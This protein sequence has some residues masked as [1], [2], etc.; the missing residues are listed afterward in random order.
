M[1]FLLDFDWSSLSSCGGVQF[2]VL[3]IIDFSELNFHR[4]SNHV[5]V[6]VQDYR[7]NSFIVSALNRAALLGPSGPF[8]LVQ[9]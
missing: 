4:C 9:C 7:A 8:I 5:L 3:L 1:C 2:S 6:Q